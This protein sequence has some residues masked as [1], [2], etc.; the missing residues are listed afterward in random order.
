[1]FTIFATI[2]LLFRPT[3]EIV[4]NLSSGKSEALMIVICE[5]G[6]RRQ[7][8]IRPSQ[9]PRLNGIA[10]EH[11]SYN[12]TIRQ[13]SSQEFRKPLVRNFEGFLDCVRFS[14]AKAPHSLAAILI[15][16]G[17]S[18]NSKGRG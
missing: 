14:P 7:T 13:L 12:T 2:S 1:M 5:Y 6:P 17:L 4:R 16:E 18:I 8:A 15:V 11:L 3:S 10:L 9:N